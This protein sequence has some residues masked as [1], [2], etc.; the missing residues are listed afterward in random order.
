MFAKYYFLVVL[1]GLSTGERASVCQGSHPPE[2]DIP[3]EQTD[4]QQ[5][6]K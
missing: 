2:A 3:V 4:G 1:I 5:V 6:S